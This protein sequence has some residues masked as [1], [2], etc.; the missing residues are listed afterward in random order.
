MANSLAV[1]DAYSY[2]D[3]NRPSQ[4]YSPSGG[5]TLHRRAPSAS[6]FRPE[7]GDNRFD[8]PEPSWNF[9]GCSHQEKN[10]SHVCDALVSECLAARERLLLA[11][12]LDWPRII[13][14]GDSKI[15]IDTLQGNYSAPALIVPLTRHIRS[16]R[17]QFE[18]H[19]RVQ[20]HGLVL[21]NLKLVYPRGPNYEVFIR[22][23]RFKWAGPEKTHC[24]ECEYVVRSPFEDWTTHQRWDSAVVLNY[25]SAVKA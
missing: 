18:Q 3:G 22:R 15:L 2:L 4:I 23:P 7:T 9:R 21:P 24:W 10:I 5:H 19:L 17:S 20:F 13:L 11:A 14:E 25:D 16:L 8:C 1:S 6:T 12:E